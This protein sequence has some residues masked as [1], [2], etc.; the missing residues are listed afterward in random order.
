MLVFNEYLSRIKGANFCQVLKI[1]AFIQVKFFITSG[2]QKCK[3]A[4]PN[5]RSRA[6]FKI[7]SIMSEKIKDLIKYIVR[8]EKIKREEPIL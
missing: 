7:L 5:L 3:G 6:R 2:N 1:K 4:A 8:V